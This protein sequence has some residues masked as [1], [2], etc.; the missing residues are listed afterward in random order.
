MQRIYAI[1]PLEALKMS[2]Q[3]EK[4]IVEFYKKAKSLFLNEEAQSILKK[5]M[6]SSINNRQQSINQYSKVSGKRIL[7]LNLDKKHRLNSLIHCGKN[8]RESII[9]AKRNEKELI[10][11]YQTL[12]RR[13][14]DADLRAFFRKLS[15]EH[16]EN[17]EILDKK[18]N[19][20]SIFDEPAEKQNAEA[21]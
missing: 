1:E 12:S 20:P 16:Q 14:L 5:M 10:D 9:T 4:E 2:I 13:F 7:Y 21:A 17:F 15:D 18:F 8:N 19:D 6:D 11:F 3:S